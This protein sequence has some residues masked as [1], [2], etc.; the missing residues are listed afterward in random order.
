M[1]KIFIF[2][3]ICIM[4]FLC[5][6]SGLGFGKKETIVDKLNNKEKETNISDETNLDS[7]YTSINPISINYTIL[8]NK[9]G[10]SS[11]ILLNKNS[12]F[13]DEQFNDLKESFDFDNNT[14]LLLNT[15]NIDINNIILEEDSNKDNI[16]LDL[17]TIEK[18]D[19][20]KSI[21]IEIKNVKI[22]NIS[23]IHLN[24]VN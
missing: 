11:L 3:I 1:K 5:I 22:Y 10:E 19:F 4:L 8:D 13:E 24:F 18:D 23:Y 15:S 12:N 20:N 9:I 14:Y 2:L 21:I 6:K 16:N 7:Y 17:Y